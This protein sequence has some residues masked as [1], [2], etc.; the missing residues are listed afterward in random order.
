M[1]KQ[2]I[3]QV[4]D[5][6]NLYLAFWKARKGKSHAHNVEVYRTG[7]GENLIDLREQILTGLVD[8]GDYYYF[9]IYE[10]KERQICAAA[11]G[12]QVLHHALMNVCHP[13]FERR[14]ISDSYASRKGKGTYAA[15]G[16]ARRF[17][18]NHQWFLKLDVRK[19]FESIHHDVVRVQLTKMFK[20]PKLLEILG[21]ILESYEASPKRG[22]PIGNLT[23]QYFANHYLAGLDH[24]V[25][26][27]LGIRAYVRYMDDIVLW[28]NEKKELQKAQEAIHAYVE[29]RLLCTLKP[30]QLNQTA[31]GLP[32]LGYMVKPYYM[33]LLQQSKIRF[34]RK[35][36]FA[37][38][39]LESGVWGEASY[40]R[41]ILPLLAFTQ[42]AETKGFR[43]KLF[44]EDK[45]LLP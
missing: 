12:E 39:Q 21:K 2:L 44:M 10:P 29:N 14:Q 18:C 43:A 7:L 35:W 40:Q 36:R 37:E 13:Y 16:Q 6:D 42:H 32:F 1:T 28:S 3:E 26:N 17:T 24:F 15:L 34:V 27:E 8:V 11:F 41:H 30:V 19:F 20:D 31:Q 38:Q 9:K 4:A 25:K 45:G 23:S 5:L 22:L 33:R